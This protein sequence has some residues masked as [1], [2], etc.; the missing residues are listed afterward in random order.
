MEIKPVHCDLCNKTQ[1]NSMHL[2][3]VVYVPGSVG[4]IRYVCDECY[5]K[6]SIKPDRTLT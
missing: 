4:V 2:C 5:D 1:E 3:H 6:N